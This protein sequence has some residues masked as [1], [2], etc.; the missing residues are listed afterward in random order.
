M[1][2]A[3]AILDKLTY[4]LP[5]VQ[6]SLNEDTGVTLTNRENFLLYKPG[7]NLDLK[8][9]LNAEV[10]PGSGVHR[11]MQEKRRVAL[12]FDKTLYGIPYTSVATPVY[13]EKNEVIGAIAITQ[14]VELQEIIKKMSTG[15]VDNISTLAATCE[16]ISAQTE[17]I[18]ASS[19]IL[20]EVARD[21]Q[22]RVKQS[23]Q[24]LEL[25]RSIASQT[26]LLGLNA[27]IE[28]ARVGELGRGFG[29]VAAEIRK[30]AGTSAQSTNEV[31]S[32]IA[33]IRKNSDATYAQMNDMQ[34]AIGQIATAV[35]QIADTIQQV[36]QSA[37][38]LDRIAETMN[39]QV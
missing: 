10:K 28:A 31:G 35:N 3:E 26:N 11:A 24:V 2:N 34:N 29:V 38:E 7:K 20:T 27:A 15:L 14:P 5:L 6:L 23:D 8:V 21:S 4:T 22:L 36:N 39:G 17:E 18:A 16:E 30:L 19:R 9:P 37:A 12:R 25:I 1:T 32:I 13:D 33:A